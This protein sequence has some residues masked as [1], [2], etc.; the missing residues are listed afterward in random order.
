MT[1]SENLLTSQDV[2]DLPEV[3]EEEVAAT[4]PI[5]ENEI[6]VEV[7]TLQRLQTDIQAKLQRKI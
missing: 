2:L 1:P 3:N 4:P 7:S 6:K 5:N